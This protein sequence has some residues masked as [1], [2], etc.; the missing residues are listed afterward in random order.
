MSALNAA[1]ITPSGLGN[2]QVVASGTPS[3]KNWWR[4]EP[5]LTRVVLVR[6]VQCHQML[7]H[8]ND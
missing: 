7:G 4:R 2:A 8:L 5:Q 3:L 6:P 1:P